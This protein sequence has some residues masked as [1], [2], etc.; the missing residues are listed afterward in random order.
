MP[1]KPQSRAYSII[2]L[3]ATYSNGLPSSIILFHFAATSPAPFPSPISI[4]FPNPL[5]YTLII[6]GK[7]NR[8]KISISVLSVLYW[9]NSFFRA[10]I[11]QIR[12]GVEMRVSL[13]LKTRHMGHSLLFHLIKLLNVICLNTV[14]LIGHGKDYEIVSFSGGVGSNLLWAGFYFHS[15]VILLY[16]I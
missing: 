1:A 7:T 6:I 12:I 4:I 16:I 11:V 10:I 9:N 3:S 2:Y 8:K 5:Y 13:L 15:I 14:T